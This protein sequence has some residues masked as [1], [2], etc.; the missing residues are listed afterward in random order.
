[1]CSRAWLS[2]IY[3]RKTRAEC[4]ISGLSL[5]L[6]PTIIHLFA[7]CRFML[8]PLIVMMLFQVFSFRP[9]H[10]TFKNIPFVSFSTHTALT[11]RSSHF[12]HSWLPALTNS[13][14]DAPHRLSPHQGR[15]QARARSGARHGGGPRRCHAQRGHQPGPHCLCQ[16]LLCGV[17]YLLDA[18]G[19]LLGAQHPCLV[20]AGPL[21]R[22][23]RLHQLVCAAAV[24]SFRNGG[25]LEKRLIRRRSTRGNSSE[26]LVRN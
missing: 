13:T 22:P 24:A 20:H 17:V 12:S 6:F 8:V 18:A 5:S 25:R 3:A 7:C 14:C 11:I 16:R 23:A 2:H 26:N 10:L 4:I 19:H 9:R 1:M 15:R 21:H